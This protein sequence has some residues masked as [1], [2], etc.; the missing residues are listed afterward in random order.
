MY[1]NLVFRCS[2]GLGRRVF[3]LLCQTLEFFERLLI[4]QIALLYPAFFTSRRAHAHKALV[5]HSF[6]H[7]Q[8]LTVMHHSG[9]VI[10]GGD[11]VAQAC[12]C[13]RYVSVFPAIRSSASAASGEN[14]EYRG[15]QE[16]Q[17]KNAAIDRDKAC[18]GRFPHG[19]Y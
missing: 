14:K 13:N 16:F 10:D 1:F 17:K 7:L 9:L 3:E 15:K 11:V 4:R 5:L 19:V 6:Q 18:A 2:A 12:L 8:P